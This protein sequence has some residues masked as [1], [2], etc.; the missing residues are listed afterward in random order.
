MEWIL[1]YSSQ[2]SLSKSSTSLA[3]HFTDIFF[4]SYPLE[5]VKL[6]LTAILILCSKNSD[7]K[8][9]FTSHTAYILDEDEKLLGQK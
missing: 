6:T 8:V 4:H 5:Q 1:S 7:Q 9:L 3:Q 2:L